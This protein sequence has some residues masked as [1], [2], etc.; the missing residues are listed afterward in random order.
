[1]GER[2]AASMF[3]AGRTI[4]KDIRSVEKGFRMKNGRGGGYFKA[5]PEPVCNLVKA[6]APS[7]A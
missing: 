5:A 2:A 3:Y 7:A 6:G 1:M 4:D